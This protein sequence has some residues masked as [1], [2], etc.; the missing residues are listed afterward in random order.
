[1]KVVGT[2]IQLVNN[3]GQALWLRCSTDGGATF[4]TGNNYSY[5]EQYYGSD[6]SNDWNRSSADSKMIVMLP[7]PDSSTS[8]NSGSFE[9]NLYNMGN[10]S[11]HATFI[12]EVTANQVNTNYNIRFS[13]SYNVT[14]AVNA[15][16]FLG[17]TANIFSGNFYLYGIN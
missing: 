15:I 10:A 9:I 3:G 16:R 2:G 12:G 1:M 4:D 17:A 6:S 11:L 5:N 8:T 14:G 13:G 7:Y